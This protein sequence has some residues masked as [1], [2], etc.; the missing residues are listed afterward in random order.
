MV[1]VVDTINMFLISSIAVDSVDT[2]LTV[3]QF[4]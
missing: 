1:L 3:Y 4:L 2:W